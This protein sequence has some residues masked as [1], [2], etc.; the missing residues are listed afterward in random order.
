L[1]THRYD[2]SGCEPCRELAR[3]FIANRPDDLAEAAFWHRAE[4]Y[5]QQ[6]CSR[7]GFKRSFFFSAS[8]R[9]SRTAPQQYYAAKAGPSIQINRDFRFVIQG[10]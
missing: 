9:C 5:R 7:K 4:A 3:P 2:Y 8:I 10:G 1:R 6:Q